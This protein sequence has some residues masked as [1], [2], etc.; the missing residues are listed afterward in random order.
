MTRLSF[1]LPDSL[2]RTIEALAERDGYSVDQFLASAAA[3]KV[4]ALQTV[5]FLRSEAARGNRE[6]F[7]RFLSAVPA[8]EPIETDR[9]P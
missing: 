6:D 1:Q 8:R 5:D 7:D 9:F 2:R 4:A 3:E